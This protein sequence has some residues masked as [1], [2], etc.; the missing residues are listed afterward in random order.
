MKGNE[1]FYDSAKMSFHSVIHEERIA[2][3][4]DSVRD[5]RCSFSTEVLENENTRGPSTDAYS[6]LHDNVWRTTEANNLTHLTSSHGIKALYFSLLMKNLDMLEET[7][8]DSE[9]IRLERDILVQLERLGALKLFQTYLFRTL[10]PSTSSSFP[11]S[12]SN[13][14]EAAQRNGPVDDLGRKVLVHSVRKEERRS[15]RKRLLEK[16][17]KELERHSKTNVTG[18]QLPTLSSGKRALNSRI[19]RQRIAR[20]EAEM[21]RGVK[22]LFRFVSSYKKFSAY[23]IFTSFKSLFL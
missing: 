21:S 11:G 3:L 20:N 14:V 6:M 9:M 5:Q 4:G 15:R 2:L 1:A 18:R 7:I 12:P 22:V 16:S 23:E 19:R 13:I 17:S 10:K 8:S